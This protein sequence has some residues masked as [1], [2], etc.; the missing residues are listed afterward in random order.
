VAGCHSDLV[1]IYTKIV[2]SDQTQ[3]RL[4][5]SYYRVGFYGKPFQELDGK[6]YVYKEPK[7]T[8]LG[9]IKER[10]VELFSEKFKEPLV[11]ITDSSPVDKAKLDAK[12]PSVQLTSVAVYFDPWELKERSSFYEKNSRMSN[13]LVFCDIFRSICF[14]DTFYRKSK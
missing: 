3:S 13:F 6:E 5:G 7:I 2:Q 14:F 1:E 12:I 4:L 9:E 10:L 8:R 11:F